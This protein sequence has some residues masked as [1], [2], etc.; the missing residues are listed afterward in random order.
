MKPLFPSQ[1]VTVTLVA[2][3][4]CSVTKSTVTA[5]VSMGCLGRAAMLV[6]VDSLERSRTATAVISA[7]LSGM[8]SLVS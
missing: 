5:C 7:L 4:G 8:L 1:H 6:P 2:S 3:L